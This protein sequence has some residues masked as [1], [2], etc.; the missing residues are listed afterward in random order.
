MKQKLHSSPEFCFLTH[1]ASFPTGFL[2]RGTSVGHENH[3]VISHTLLVFSMYISSCSMCYAKL[4]VYWCLFSAKDLALQRNSSDESSGEEE[5][6]L[7]R[8]DSIQ[9]SDTEESDVLLV[10][11]GGC[12]V[13]MFDMEE[14]S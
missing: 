10:T 11:D 12:A 6:T 2:N 3:A 13:E 14:R 9:T 5:F 4:S 7:F 1:L 8:A